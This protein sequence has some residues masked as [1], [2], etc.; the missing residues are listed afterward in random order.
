MKTTPNGVKEHE[1]H[2]AY[3]SGKA[4]MVIYC[5]QLKLAWSYMV[6]D[7]ILMSPDEALKMVQAQAEAY[8]DGVATGESL[9][10]FAN[11]LALAKIK[12]THKV[13]L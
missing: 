6:R 1:W 11:Y 7:Y 2:L 3:R 9:L 5:P 13:Y 12:C 4:I 8:Y 10:S